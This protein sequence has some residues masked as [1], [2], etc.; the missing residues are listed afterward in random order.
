MR[1]LHQGFEGLGLCQVGRSVRAWVRPNQ[2]RF[3]GRSVRWPWAAQIF[4]WGLDEVLS[5]HSSLKLLPPSPSNGRSDRAAAAAAAAAEEGR[6]GRAAPPPAA[7]G[8]RGIGARI[9]RRLAQRAAAEGGDGGKK[10]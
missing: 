4:I 8:R 7:T 5:S 3:V 6:K 2:A 10:Y 1:A 9:G